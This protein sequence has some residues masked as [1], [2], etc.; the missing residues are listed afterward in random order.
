MMTNHGRNKAAKQN[1]FSEERRE[2]GNSLFSI[3]RR[4]GRTASGTTEEKRSQASS[5][6]QTCANQIKNKDVD[7]HT[8]T[9]RKVIADGCT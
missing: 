6:A 3:K 4:K 8:W 1:S 9:L 2:R 7:R 5:R